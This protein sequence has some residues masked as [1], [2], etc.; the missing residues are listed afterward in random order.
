MKQIDLA[1][2]AKINLTLDIKGL[3]SNG[4]HEMET[5]MQSVSLHDTITIK[6]SNEDIKLIC[7][8]RFIPTD[9]RNLAYRAADIFLQYTGLQQG[10]VIGIKKRIPVQAGL[11]GGSADAAAVLFGM[12]R[13]FETNLTLESLAILG[14]NLGADIPFCITGGTKLGKGF[15]EQLFDVTPLNPCYI[16][17]VKPSFGSSTVQAFHAY[18]QVQKT[19]FP[20]TDLFTRALAEG[21][22]PFI[23]KQL[24]NVL[25]PVVKGS[26]QIDKIKK[27]IIRRGA[28]GAVMS[29][30]GSA[31]FGIFSSRTL[32]QNCRYSMQKKYPFATVCSPVNQGVAVLH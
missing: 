6:K 21:N 12:N 23:G 32:A 19:V 26:E 18:D 31:V 25:E 3:L 11:G 4:F 13:L 10:V 9:S 30:S 27:S 14:Q 22:L 15:G 16:L 5:I 17:I 8:H 20:D 29:G 28:M 7:N 1:A 24:K 2:Y